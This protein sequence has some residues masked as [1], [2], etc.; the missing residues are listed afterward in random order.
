MVT[1]FRSDPDFVWRMAD[2]EADGFVEKTRLEAMPD[3][4]TAALAKNGRADH[5]DCARC[6]AESAAGSVSAAG[7]AGAAGI[8]TE[9]RNDGVAGNARVVIAVDGAK[10]KR[11][12]GFLV[13]GRRTDL[14]DGKS[15]PFVRLVVAHVRTPG[16]YVSTTALGMTKDKWVVIRIREAFKG[17]LPPGFAIIEEGGRMFR[18]NP[19]VVVER[20][21]WAVLAGHPEVQVQKMAREVGGA[22]VP[23]D[24]LPTKLGAESAER[25]VLVALRREVRDPREVDLGDH[26]ARSNGLVAVSTQRENAKRP[27]LEEPH[28]ADAEPA[29]DIEL[30]D[31]SVGR[32]DFE[33][34]IR[35]LAVGAPAVALVGLESATSLVLLKS[36]GGVHGITQ[37]LWTRQSAA[38]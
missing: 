5:A 16:S 11:R 30:V 36:G 37:L 29:V 38:A 7:V 18:F 19:S 10:N 13:N 3:K 24:R 12:T 17:M 27:R 32:D 22:V 4:L 28:F 20:V 34:N 14:Q 9:T 26:F 25:L 33:R 8:A 1:A 6:N 15:V 21:E 23:G 31:R 2:L 35:D